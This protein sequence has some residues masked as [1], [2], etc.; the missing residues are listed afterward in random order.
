MEPV[1]AAGESPP[2]PSPDRARWGII[3]LV[4]VIAGIAA[5]TLLPPIL[6]PPSGGNAVTGTVLPSPAAPGFPATASPGP[7]GP[8]DFTVT[9]SPAQ[10][11]AG[12][13]ETVVYRMTIEPRNGFSGEIHMELQASA[14]F[15]LVSQ[16]HDLG[17]QEPPYP[18]TVEYAFTVPSNWPSGITINGVVRST[19]GGITREDPLTLTVR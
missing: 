15:G 2:L 4:L 11:T 19:G 6:A 13:G 17:I 16:T 8:P 3:A 10:A 1:P 7:G 9:I 14:L 12:R 18:K 5:A